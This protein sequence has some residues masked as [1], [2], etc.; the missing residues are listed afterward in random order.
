MRWR[1]LLARRALPFV[2]LGLVCLWVEPGL[3]GLAL[4][5]LLA[6]VAWL[7][8]Y[9]PYVQVGSTLIIQNFFS[10]SEVEWSEVDTVRPG[11][12]GVVI[13]LRDGTSITAL[14]APK[15]PLDMVLGRHARADDLCEEI[16]QRVGAVQRRRVADVFVGQR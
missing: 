15:R 8:V 4:A 10:R 3:G 13:R 12:Q 6:G 16:A 11:F 14:A 5:P 1:L 9:R 2:F 7:G